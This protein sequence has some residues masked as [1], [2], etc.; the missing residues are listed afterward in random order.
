MKH[1]L[2]AGK[3]LPFL[4]SSRVKINSNAVNLDFTMFKYNIA[5]CID[6]FNTIQNSL[7]NINWTILPFNKD[8]NEVRLV[9]L[10]SY[11]LSL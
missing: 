3:T 5:K 2:N 10:L 11:L 6:H 1:P 9:C 4:H 7:G 8:I